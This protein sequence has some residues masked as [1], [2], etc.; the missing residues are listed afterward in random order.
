ML[1]KE[2]KFAPIAG[3]LSI[4]LGIIGIATG[5][6]IIGAFIGLIGLIMGFINY[7]S[8]DSKVMAYIGIALSDLAIAWT[9][10]FYVLW[11]NIPI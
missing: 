11:D 3:P 6:Y 10:I 4:I 1:M 7:D 8:S 9:C 2:S 5:I